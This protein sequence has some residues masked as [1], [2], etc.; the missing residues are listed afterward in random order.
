[1]GPAK[2]R[3]MSKEEALQRIKDLEDPM[4]EDHIETYNLVVRALADNMN[5]PEIQRKGQWAIALGAI[6]QPQFLIQAGAVEQTVK[7]MNRWPLD[8][9]LQADGCET[10]R[11]LCSKQEGMQR[12]L[13]GGAIEAVCRALAQHSLD[14]RIQQEACGALT[15]F[16]E[17]DA[18]AALS[19][20]GYESILHAMELYPN[21][22]WVQMWAAQA[23]ANLSKENQKD[24]QDVEGYRKV[25]DAMN[26][27]DEVEAV[28]YFG[29]K[30]VM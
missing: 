20:G 12:A 26:T 3:G 11:L 7:T 17:G 21:W 22:S 30:A 19:G 15:K 2:K 25:K 29:R 14:N 18:K 23:T 8:E 27:H 6:N 13:E 16:S 9:R 4:Y 10:L 1:M 24:V 28:Q 5:N